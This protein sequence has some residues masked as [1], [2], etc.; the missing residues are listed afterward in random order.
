ML[1]RLHIGRGLIQ[2]H[3][4]THTWTLWPYR[5]REDRNNL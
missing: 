5:R 1:W 4:P 2:W 3:G